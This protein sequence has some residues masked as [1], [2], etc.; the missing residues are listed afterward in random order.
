MNYLGLAFRAKYERETGASVDDAINFVNG[1]N[2]FHATPV[3]D[4]N[5]HNIFVN[6]RSGN[7]VLGRGHAEKGKTW[8]FFNKYSQGHAW[9]YDGFING[10]SPEGKEYNLLHCN[11]GWNGELNGYYRCRVFNTNNGPVFD[12]VP[13]RSNQDPYFRYNLQYSLITPTQNPS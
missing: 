12:K 10:I 9:V 2:W 7:L 13:T 3:Q 4:Y 8:I 5:E 11:W 1:S 6:I